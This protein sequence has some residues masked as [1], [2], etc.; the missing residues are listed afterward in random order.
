MEWD[1]LRA[2]GA[3]TAASLLLWAAWAVG[4]TVY[5]YLLPQVRRGAPWLRAHG[6]WAGKRQ[7]LCAKRVA[8]GIA[9]TRTDDRRGP[10]ITAESPQSR[11]LWKQ[12]K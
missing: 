11:E 8:M 5:V 1:P 7:G 3:V 4:C 9:G 10:P 2:L 12:E 6:A